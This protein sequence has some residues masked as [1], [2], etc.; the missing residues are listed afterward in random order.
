MPAP[1]SRVLLRGGSVHSPAHPAATAMVTVDGTVAWVGDERGAAGQVREVDDVRDLAGRLVTPGFVDAHVH[2]GKTGFALQTLDLSTATSL[3]DALDQ[4]A[5]GCGD[6]TGRVVVAHGWDESRWPEDRA[7]TGSELDR[8]VGGRVAYASRVD[9]HSAVVTAALVELDPSIAT[10]PG[11]RGNGAVDRDAHHAARAVVDSL[12]SVDERRAA[13]LTALR[14]AASVGLTCVHEVNAPH[15]A[16]YDDLDLVDSL[17]A[18]H[19][20]P[21]VVGYW[22]ALQGG[23]HPDAAVAGFAGDLCADGAL[24][25][26][27][28]ALNAPYA[29]ADT[30]GHLYVDAQH[31]RDHVVWCT[32]RGVQAGFHVIGD[33]ALDAVVAGLRQAAERLGTARMVAARHRLEHVEMPSTEGIA[34]LA[35]LGVVAS[36]QPA[37][38]AAWGGAEDLYERR[39]G[40]ERASTMNPFATMHRA[41][42]LLAFGSDSPVTPMAPWAGV[43]AAVLHSRSD[44]RLSL[45]AAFA[46]HTRGGH[47]ARGHDEAGVLSPGADASY[48]IWDASGLPPAPDGG[49]LPDIAHDGALPRCVRT[50]VSGAVAFDAEDP[51]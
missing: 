18:E 12:R 20:L 33:R 49:A 50:V 7:F 34:V 10:L 46:A 23:E 14:R 31:V 16:P 30:S 43:R 6:S 42:V 22:G 27:T 19:V 44:E 4:L 25:S 1:H 36:V 3:P 28:A 32:G 39:L 51:A 37:F 35:A 24:G 47:R 5:N 45:A 41:G 15:I 40:A 13:L 21:E 8:A 9:A 2:V 29:D 38:D 26:R 11:W 17:R 48:A